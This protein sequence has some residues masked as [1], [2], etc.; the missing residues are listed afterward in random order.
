MRGVVVGPRARKRGMVVLN[1]PLLGVGGHWD[2]TG[3]CLGAGGCWDRM[4]G[5]RWRRVLGCDVKMDGRA[6]PWV[7]SLG[8][9]RAHV[10]DSC[11]DATLGRR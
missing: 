10:G 11:R 9:G 5:Y 1:Q 7:Q 4:L 8:C 2:A 3:R 6:T